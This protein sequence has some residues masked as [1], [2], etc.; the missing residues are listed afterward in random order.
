MHAEAV[1]A[2]ENKDK[3]KLAQLLRI[4][5]E[6]SRAMLWHLWWHRHAGISELRSLIN[7]GNDFEVLQRLKEVINGQAQGLWG[8]PVVTFEQSKFDP[9]TGEKVLFN[10]WFQD[11]EKFSLPDKG[12]S[13]MDVL[14]EQDS[15]TIITQLRTAVDLAH[16][17][18]RFKNGILRVRLGKK[19][20][21]A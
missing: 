12:T 1:V 16:P 3:A 20:D 18:L 21:E 8:R 15:V 13:L 6:K 11:E 14:D 19:G 17:D 5:D 4:L 9:A 2:G 10:W 7:A